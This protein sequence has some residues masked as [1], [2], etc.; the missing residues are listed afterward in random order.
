MSKKLFNKPSNGAIVVHDINGN[1]QKILIKKLKLRVAVYGI[2]KNK[3]SILL[4][5]NPIVEKY[6]LPGGA[7]ELGEKIKDSLV[8]E[9]HEETGISVKVT[10]LF[11]VKEDFFVFGNE[12]A[13]S[14]LL[15]YEVEKINGQHVNFIKTDD[16]EGIKF[17]NFSKI[18]LESFTIPFK[19]VLQ[20]IV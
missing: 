16:S 6:N 13:H 19:E 15:F 9:Y 3:E 7:V 2:L 18:D 10:K 20:S 4:Q 17:I 1:T 12:Y 5:W 11:D 8:R 14:I